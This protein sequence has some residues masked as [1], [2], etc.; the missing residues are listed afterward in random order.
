M[1]EKDLESTISDKDIHNAI[2]LNFWDDTHPKSA[3]VLLGHGDRNRE[4]QYKSYTFTYDL[5]TDP[6]CK[7][8]EKLKTILDKSF[9]KDAYTAVIVEYVD[10][11]LYRDGPLI[12]FGKITL[13]IEKGKEVHINEEELRNLL[14]IHNT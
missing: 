4:E 6:Y 13:F 7:I 1:E 2:T 8:D 9:M 12:V 3:F 5:S 11:W 10:P 14:K